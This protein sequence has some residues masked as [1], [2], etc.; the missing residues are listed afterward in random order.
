MQD[1]TCRTS[2]GNP[3]N[4]EG[5]LARWR[6]DIIRCRGRGQSIRFLRGTLSTAAGSSD[7]A[8]TAALRRAACHSCHSVTE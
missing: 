6:I 3:D 5:C 4:G 8:R 1:V 2:L 7:T